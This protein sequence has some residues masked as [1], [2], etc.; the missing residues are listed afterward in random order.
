MVKKV[1]KKGTHDFSFYIFKWLIICI[2]GILALGLITKP[3]RRMWATN[4]FEKGESYLEQ[5]KYES[6][7]LEYRKS[8]FL[9]WKNDQASSRIALARE[10][11]VDILKLEN[12]YRERKLDSQL[13]ILDEIAQIPTDETEAIKLSKELI[14]KGEY[15]Y[16]I[17][18]AQTGTEMGRD[19]RDAWLYLGIANLKAMKMLELTDDS[20]NKYR[21]D[22]K[23]ALEKAKSLDSQYQPTKDYLEELNKIK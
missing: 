9:F 21:D 4:Y 14:E 3:L 19:F 10:S 11:S 5:K 23:N 16:A 12:F 6:A 22:A 7:I 2:I 18:S 20:R 17:V 1:D 15:Q 8:L 13:Q